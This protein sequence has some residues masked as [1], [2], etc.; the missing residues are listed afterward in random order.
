MKGHW[1]QFLLFLFLIETTLMPNGA[2]NT[3][4]QLPPWLSCCATGQW[5]ES[6]GFRIVKFCFFV[7]VIHAMPWPVE[8]NVLEY[9]VPTPIIQ[10]ILQQRFGN[11]KTVA[12][13]CSK[14][15]NKL[16]TVKVILLSSLSTNLVL[17][18]GESRLSTSMEI[19]VSQGGDNLALT[20][21]ITP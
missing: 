16:L 5:A 17:Q 14:T 7:M 1:I 9:F 15:Q 18:E 13:F 10:E 8:E 11:M 3:Q 12:Q 20:I 19:A 6:L 4:T 2:W 21:K